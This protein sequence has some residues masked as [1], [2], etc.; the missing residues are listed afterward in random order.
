M[1]RA[2]DNADA[3]LTLLI[4]AGF[5]PNLHLIVIHSWNLWESQL[6]VYGIQIL[7]KSQARD[8]QTDRRTDGVQHLVVPIQVYI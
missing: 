4:T 6:L 5:F 7:S 8:R 3:M 1:V 2:V